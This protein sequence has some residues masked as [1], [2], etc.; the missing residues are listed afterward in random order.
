MHIIEHNIIYSDEVSSRLN[1]AAK[2]LADGVYERISDKIETYADSPELWPLSIEDEIKPITDCQRALD[3]VLEKLDGYGFMYIEG[4]SF[5]TI[6]IAEKEYNV[7]QEEQEQDDEDIMTAQQAAKLSR[8]NLSERLSLS[9]NHIATLIRN[10]ASNGD[11][12]IIISATTEP[13]LGDATVIKKITK[14]LI[15]DGYTVI[16]G[17][18]TINNVPR[19]DYSRFK[20]LTI[21]WEKV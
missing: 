13:V 18:K 9:N 8:E 2:R 4:D 6:E 21:S 7:F 5:S 12:K 11:T 14:K 10:A 16:A 19:P 20:K 1:V 3:I 17:D 15:N